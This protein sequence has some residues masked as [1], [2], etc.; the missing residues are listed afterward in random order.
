MTDEDK[1]STGTR[2]S[3]RYGELLPFESWE[4]LDEES[5]AAFAAFSAYRDY[6]PERNMR[7]AVEAAES[8]P[9]K[10]ARRYRV[11]RLWSMQHKWLRRAA[12]YDKYCD[13]LK[14]AERRK[15]LENLEEKQGKIVA[16]ML[17]LTDK[18]VAL[19]TPEDLSPTMAV[20][21]LDAATRTKRELAGLDRGGGGK[22]DPQESQAQITFGPDFEGL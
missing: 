9:H 19:M 5:S 7:K 20:E 13:R 6:G 12:D 10:A 3:S 15:V 18:K 14:L 2:Q 16:G 17:D 11:W 21:F 1:G 8:D 4:K 22:D